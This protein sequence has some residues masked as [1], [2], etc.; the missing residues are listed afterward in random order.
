VAGGD[1]RASADYPRFPAID[2]AWSAVGCKDGEPHPSY[3]FEAGMANNLIS[4]SPIIRGQPRQLDSGAGRRQ[5]RSGA[6]D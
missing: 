2:D 5:G 1:A 6:R 4:T 3:P